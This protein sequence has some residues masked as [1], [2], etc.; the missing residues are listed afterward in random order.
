VRLRVTT[1]RGSSFT[2]D[3]CAGGFCTELMRVLPAGAPVEG[4]ISLGGRD[5][6]F[7]GRVAWARPGDSRLNQVGRMGVCFVRIEPE[8]ARRLAASEALAAS[9]AI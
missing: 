9:A 4:L 3:V 8:F 5:A 1:S 2:V 7:A 6:S